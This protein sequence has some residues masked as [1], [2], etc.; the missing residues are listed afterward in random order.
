MVLYHS[1]I[2]ELHW[3][4]ESV[5]FPFPNRTGGY[6]NY[7]RMAALHLLSQREHIY[8]ALLSTLW[9]VM[10]SGAFGALKKKNLKWGN[11]WARQG[12]AGAEPL[13]S[14]CPGSC[15]SENG[16]VREP[17]LIFLQGQT[18]T[19]RSQELSC[20]GAFLLP[21]SKFS[22]WRNTPAQA[23]GDTPCSEGHC[24][25]SE[26]HWSQVLGTVLPLDVVVVLC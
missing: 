15:V 19:A 2:F 26:H 3:L 13:P 4:Q 7:T 23:I 6:Q 16:R 14:T 25:R 12:V 21:K 11:S 5:T 18:A 20:I 10:A 1:S 9:N 8:R 22:G 17:F 24:F